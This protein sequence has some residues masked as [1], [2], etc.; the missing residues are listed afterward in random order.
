MVMLTMWQLPVDADILLHNVDEDEYLISQ[1]RMCIVNLW[2][3]VWKNK[4][5]K[6]NKLAE[7]ADILQH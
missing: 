7:S 6:N 3:I 2:S 4:G 1:D 5:T